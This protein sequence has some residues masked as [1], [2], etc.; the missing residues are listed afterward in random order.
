MGVK[1]W[2]PAIAGGV[3]F[4]ALFH[5]FLLWVADSPMAIYALTFYSGGQVLSMGTF[6]ILDYLSQKPSYGHLAPF[7]ARPDQTRFARSSD[8]VGSTVAFFGSWLYLVFVTLMILSGRYRQKEWQDSYDR[9]HL[10]LWRFAA[11]LAVM[12]PISLAARIIL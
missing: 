1:I 10:S 7:F 8:R 3:A 9:L 4:I 5:C 6:W 12:A 2:V 11:V